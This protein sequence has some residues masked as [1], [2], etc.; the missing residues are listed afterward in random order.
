MKRGLILVLVLL[1]ALLG[2]AVA[3]QDDA[4]GPTVLLGGNDELGAFFTDANG[5]T[6]YVFTRDELGVSNCSGDCAAA[7]PPLTVEEGQNPSLDPAIS[8]VVSAIA[9]DDGTRQV[10]YNGWPLY[11]YVED[12]AAGDTVG[13]GVND[14]WWVAAMPNVGLGGNAE[15]GDFLVDNRGMTLYTFANDTEGVSN[16]ADAC[17]E[18]WPPLAVA[19]AD[20]LTTQPGL[21][22]EFSTIERADGS[23]QVALNGMPLYTFIR[24]TQPGEAV[25]HLANDVWFAAKL[26]T[27]AAAESEEFG[28]ILTGPNGMTLYTFANDEAG[29]SAC[30]EGCAVA[31]PPLTVAAGEEVTVSGDLMGA[32]GTIERADGSLQV[33][34]NDAPLYYWINDVVPG[35]TTG[36]LFR[37]VWFVA[38]P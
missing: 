26:P 36:H 11:Y 4:A 16:C 1:V 18:N 24:D 10:T 25:G 33:T 19:S 22:G 35:D 15:V 29:S 21:T 34:Y 28:S 7:W 17:L 13:Q 6:L 30:V 31:W 9:R 37:D 8:G 20:A 23:L 12:Q 3:A 14:V 38:L 32:V 27:L 5:W 2:S